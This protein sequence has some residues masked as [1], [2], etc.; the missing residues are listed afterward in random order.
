VRGKKRLVHIAYVERRS[1]KVVPK[2]K[3]RARERE[4][5]E[6]YTREEEEKKKGE[7][8]HKRAHVVRKR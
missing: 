1:R 3:R 8:P 6:V 7:K 5:C 2:K 4:G